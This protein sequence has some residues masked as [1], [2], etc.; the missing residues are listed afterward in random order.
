LPLRGRSLPGRVAGPARGAAGP[1]GGVPFAVRYGIAAPI[2]QFRNRGCYSGG[3]MLIF[4]RAIFASLVLGLWLTAE[5]SAA[6]C[7]IPGHHWC[8]PGRGCCAP[9]RVCAPTSGCMRP[10]YTDCGAGRGSCPP[11]Y[12]CGPVKGCIQRWQSRGSCLHLDRPGI[13]SAATFR[14]RRTDGGVV[15]YTAAPLHLVAV[16]RRGRGLIALFGR[17]R[18]C[19]GGFI[20]IWL[21]C[22]DAACFGQ[23]PRCKPEVQAATFSRRH[24]RGE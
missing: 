20:V 8:G 6:T 9:N 12:R 16:A 3:E 18:F 4:V 5:A 2:E 17:V 7:A 14:L 19:R 24:N 23:G 22:A 21:R 1:V 13:R 11:G 15:E 10:G